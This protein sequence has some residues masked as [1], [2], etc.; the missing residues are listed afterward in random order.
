MSFLEDLLAGKFSTEECVLLEQHPWLTTKKYRS[1]YVD[2]ELDHLILDR[3]NS[4]K[5]IDVVS[6]CAGHP[7]GI[8]SSI[9]E[10]VVI[11]HINQID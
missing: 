5:G 1:F 8:R 2:T 10:E 9:P 4:I 7:E 11:H 6:V 3:L